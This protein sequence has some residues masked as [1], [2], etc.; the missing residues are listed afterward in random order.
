MQRAT[1]EFTVAKNYTSA[2]A[3][4]RDMEKLTVKVR[5]K[6]LKRAARAGAAVLQKEAKANAKR[7]DNPATPAK[8]WK[9]VVVRSG[10][11]RQQR[12]AG[13]FVFRVGVKGGARQYKNTAENRRKKRV[14]GSYE[15]PGKVYYWRFLEFG[16]SKMPAR[17]FMRSALKDKSQEAI[18]VAAETLRS[19]VAKEL[20]KL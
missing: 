11:K 5:T 2:D 9:E 13:G 10:S 12:K 8:I 20:E 19:G 3:L 1:K 14:G 15:G 18:A 4:V 6:T 7:F 16:T 17:P